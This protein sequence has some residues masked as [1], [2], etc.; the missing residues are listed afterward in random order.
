MITRPTVLILGAGASEPYGFPLGGQLT[1]QILSDSSNA[2]LLSRLFGGAYRL[3]QFHSA[4]GG[5]ESGSIDDFLQSNPSFGEIGKLAIATALLVQCNWEMTPKEGTHWYQYL[6][7]LMKEGCASFE[8]FKGNKLRIATYNY[9]TSLE[10]YFSRVLPHAF[11][12]FQEKDLEDLFVTTVPLVHLHGSLEKPHPSQGH[13][14]EH[15]DPR[16]RQLMIDAAKGILVVHDPR[17]EQYDRLSD[18]L[19][20]ARSIMTMGFGFHATNAARLRIGKT[21]ARRSQEQIFFG[22]SA[23]GLRTGERNR[24]A[25]NLGVESR[26][27]YDAD[28]IHFLREFAEL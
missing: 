18:W 21:L 13:Y 5:S 4:L 22:A 25:S 7:R 20:T 6:W 28:C 16:L 17:S 15:R 1:R 3:P 9:D 27:L 26:L 24:A 10:S 11:P 8:D 12:D 23:L 19:D 14:L 2:G